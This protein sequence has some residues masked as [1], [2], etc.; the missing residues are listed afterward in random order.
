MIEIFTIG[1]ANAD[2]IFNDAEQSVSKLHA[3]L[4]VSADGRNFYL[5]DCGSSNGTFVQRQGRWER[6]KQEVVNSDDAVRFGSTT[7]Q[8][9][10]LLRKLPRRQPPVI[11]GPPPSQPAKTSLQPYR[12]PENG[13]VEYR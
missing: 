12:N 11:K 8:M 7:V 5:V 4:T 3:E 2:L 13:Q 10:D 1:R 9:K 6:I